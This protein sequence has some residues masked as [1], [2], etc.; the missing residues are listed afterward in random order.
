V[1]IVAAI[2]A[3]VTPGFNAGFLAS[4]A[5]ALADAAARKRMIKI[6]GV[7]NFCDL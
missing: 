2:V 5:D 6:E 1:Q 7:L 3:W 4:S